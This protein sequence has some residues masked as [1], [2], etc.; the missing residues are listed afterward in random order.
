MP[1]PPKCRRV[2]QLPQVTYF[3]PSGIPMTEL[4]EIH[5]TI[6]ELEAIRLRDLKELEYEECAQK[7]AVS[8]P[9]FYRII[10][11]ARKKIAEALVN[12]FA[13]R[14]TGGNFSLAKY[15]LICKNCGHHWQD[16]ICCRRTRCP[17]CN[18]NDWY[19]INL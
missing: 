12:G 2:E 11:A 13:L 16:I 8:R 7:M 5:L 10:T 18:A 15:E 6:E 14:V 4:V 1:R 3:K 19:K 17:V 9:T